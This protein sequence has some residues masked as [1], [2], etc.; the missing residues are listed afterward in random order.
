MRPGVVVLRSILGLFTASRSTR[1]QAAASSR[2]ESPRIVLSGDSIR[3]GYGPRVAER[4]SGKAIVISPS[5]NGGDIANVLAHLD[6]W[7]LRQ[8][9][10]V[11][12]LNCG[13]HDLKRSGKDGHDQVSRRVSSKSGPLAVVGSYPPL[14]A[15]PRPANPA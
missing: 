14:I 11:V 8:K 1:G 15:K 13:L 4:L 6:E 10:D 2:P 9:P 5:E 7:V 3:L 12:H